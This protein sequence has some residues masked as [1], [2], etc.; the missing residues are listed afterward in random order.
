MKRFVLLISVLLLVTAGAAWAEY[1]TWEDLYSAAGPAGMTN[2]AFM[3]ISVGSDTNLYTV[4]MAQTGATD[5]V[6]GWASSDGGNSWDPVVEAH[7]GADPCDM[8][9]LMQFMLATAAPGPD[10]ALFVGF[11]P[12][13]ECLEQY[14][15]PLCLF[16]CMF[17]MK[18]VIYYTDDGGQTVSMAT[19]GPNVMKTPTAID[20]ANDSDTVGYIGGG[21]NLLMKTTDA[22]LTW[23]NITTLPSGSF[24]AN[25]LDFLTEDTGFMVSGDVEG[26]D[27]TADDDTWFDDD[28][29]WPD[30]EEKSVEEPEAGSLEAVQQVYARGLHR[31]RFINDADYRLAYLAKHPNFGSKG[32]NGKL[33]RT[34]D[35]GAT[36]DMLY[37]DT[38]ASFLQIQMIDENTGWI[39]TEP[40]STAWPP[41]GLFKTVDGGQSWIDYT[42]R[43]PYQTLDN[44]G[45]GWAV[46][47]M[48]FNPSGQTGF[49]GGGGQKLSYKSILFYTID[50]GETWAFDDS[51]MDWGHPILSFAWNGNNMAWQAGFDLSIYKYTQANTAPIADAGEDQGVSLNTVVT[52]DGSASYDPDGDTLTYAWEQLSGP[53]VTLTG[54]DSAQPTFTGAEAGDYEF[55]LT[56]TDS[57]PESSTDS[58]VI[59]VSST[60]DDDSDDDSD[61]DDD[62]DDASGGDDDDDDSGCGC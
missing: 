26:D 7:A 42:D 50:G 6:S 52:L 23:T 49:L 18:P 39:L 56:V 14:T 28:S 17:T 30:E 62:D 27:D 33:Y 19:T 41:F 24:T 51:I 60:G 45:Y 5:M 2:S 3:G 36:W 25:D 8:L 53:T 13:P 40:V 4:G 47:A 57:Y 61:D 54:A 58:V 34:T 20:F 59:T 31:W 29:W 22:G 12:D 55:Q 35:G 32:L 21:E 43:V 15:D 1:G 11:G 9:L 44:Q 38:N 46:S 37:S 16:V 10:S 48:T